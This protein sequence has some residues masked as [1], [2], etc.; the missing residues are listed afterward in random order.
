MVND[1]D[2]VEVFREEARD[3]LVD[4]ERCLVGLGSTP[5]DQSLVDAAFRSLHTIKGSGSMFGLVELT[6]FAHDLETA[7]VRIRESR[8]PV[9]QEIIDLALE[10]VD[11]L[12]LLV[13]GGTGTEGQRTEAS[14]I[15]ADLHA[16]TGVDVTGERGGDG[17]SD[18]YD[19]RKGGGA[20]DPG[21]YRIE[22]HPSPE[23]FVVGTNPLALLAELH[24]LGECTV[25]GSLEHLPSLEE[26]DPHR[27]YLRWS[28]S[29]EGEVER[30]AVENVFMFIDPDSRVHISAVDEPRSGGSV[31]ATDPGALPSTRSS[32]PGD[33]ENAERTSTNG[34]GVSSIKVRTD[35]LDRL[36]NLVGELVSLQAQVTLRASQLADRQMAAHA[37][38]LERLVREARGLSMEMH[39]VPVESLFAPFR[40]HVRTL[41]GELG[42]EVSLRITG[43]DTELDRNVVE[44][45]RD[46]LLHIVRNAIDH[47]IEAP[48]VRTERGKPRAGVLGL[49]A[50]YS[51]AMVRI[52]VEDDGMGLDPDRIRR[53]A[54]E[55]GIIEAGTSLSTTELHELLF[56]PGF[57]TAAT[58][59]NVSGRGVGMDVVRRNVEALSGAV[60]VSSVPGYGTTVEL[61]IP[62]TLAIVEGLLA[63]AGGQL[64]LIKL[65]YIRE[66]VDVTQSQGRSTGNILDFRGAVVPLLDLGRFFGVESDSASRKER[67]IIVVD[68]G[69]QRVGLIVDRLLGN[70]QSVVKSLGRL[71]AGIDGISGA[72]FLSD[73]T[74][75]LMLDVERVVGHARGLH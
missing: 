34:S 31:A 29:L 72:I 60:S 47:G 36:V 9:S 39:M 75:A 27:C 71:L 63:E 57:S 1:V 62:L 25:V 14:R 59:T 16:L 65:E 35:R 44:Q 43:N 15:V 7:F 32:F 3:L 56:A 24:E 13:D 10:A 30:S 5:D 74:P 12:S 73:G 53:R 46:P 54:E 58:A 8:A 45:L 55:R 22:Y 52:R 11:H 40:R 28:I 33:T 64:F 20:N 23:T 48:D 38:Q 49:S 2:P 66:C 4:L 19:D 37:E 50:D 17:S 26:F 61:R 67:A 18:R 21:A 69:D 70:H 51:G 68:A 42:R 41:A 6:G